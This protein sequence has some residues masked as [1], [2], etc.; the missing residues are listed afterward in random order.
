[1]EKELQK[2]LKAA[3]K[4][5]KKL[6]EKISEVAKI[7]KEDATYGL[8][9]GKLKFK[10]LNLEREKLTKFYAIG[11]RTYKLYQEGLITDK[12]TIEL[13]E[14]LSK[15]ESLSKKHHRTAEKLLKEIKFKK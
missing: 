4:G 11:K 3:E 6:T 8:K 12:E 2:L 9:I 1:M 13:C 7:A 10:E 5:L 14:Q 15:I